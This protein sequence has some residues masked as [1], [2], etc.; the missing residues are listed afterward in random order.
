MFELLKIVKRGNL[1][2]FDNDSKNY[3]G[4]NF[5]VPGYIATIKFSLRR[6]LVLIKSCEQYASGCEWIC[7]QLIEIYSGRTSIRRTP[8]ENNTSKESFGQQA[9]ISITIA[10]HKKISRQIIQYLSFSSVNQQ[11]HNACHYRNTCCIR[12][13]INRM[14]FVFVYFNRTNVSNFFLMRKSDLR[15]DEH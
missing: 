6:T 4:I 8:S 7:S 14:I 9:M 3:W 12:W 1:N 5:Y 15:K 2:H 10:C 13:P 11:Y